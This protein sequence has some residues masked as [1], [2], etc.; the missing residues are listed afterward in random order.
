MHQSVSFGVKGDGQPVNQFVLCI[1][2]ETIYVML[3]EG[4]KRY[5]KAMHLL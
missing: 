2:S 5:A 1:N 4:E 3:C